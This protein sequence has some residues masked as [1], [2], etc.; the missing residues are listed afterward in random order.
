MQYTRLEYDLDKIAREGKGDIKYKVSGF[1]DNDAVSL[2]IQREWV[3][4][5]DKTE[6]FF[7]W[8]I[9]PETSQYS[10]RSRSEVDNDI[11]AM[12][13]VCAALADA[14]QLGRSIELEVDRMEEIFLVAEAQRQAEEERKQ[15]EAKALYDADGPVGMKLAKHI[16]DQMVYE[17]RSKNGGSYD[18]ITIY[19]STRGQR[20]ERDLN[21]RFA[22]S[23]LTLFTLGWHRVSKRKALEALADSAID[24]LRVDSINVVDPKLAKFMMV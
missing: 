20:R 23:G 16:I 17:I 8:A 1:R 11:S 5:L 4:E 15:A 22:H 3:R 24:S 10:R 14:C 6:T 7:R 21:V 9:T 19:F 13:N 18:E 2:I 12:E